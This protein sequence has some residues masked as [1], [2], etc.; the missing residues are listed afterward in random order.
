[1]SPSEERLKGSN[2][3][4]PTLKE[5]IA[6]DKQISWQWT[7]KDALYMYIFVNVDALY[8]CTYLRYVRI[9]MAYVCIYNLEWSMPSFESGYT[10]W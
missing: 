7:H 8:I 1:M 9:Y 5:V 4:F 6:K 10:G 2:Q 3:Y